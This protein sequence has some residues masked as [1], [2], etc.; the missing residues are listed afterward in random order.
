MTA[1]QG[2]SARYH[3]APE[4]AAMLLGI[5]GL[6]AMW[7]FIGHLYIS[8][9]YD[10][11]FVSAAGLGWLKHILFFHFLA[12]DMFLM[13]SGAL[14]Y[15][16]YRYYFEA[17]SKSKDIDLFY[18]HRLA[19]LYP[20]YIVTLAIIG[21]YEWV[22]IPHPVLSGMGGQIFAH[23]ELSLILNVLFMNAWGIFPVA[24]WNEPSWTLSIIMLLY[25]I[26]P[27]VVML[28]KLMPK[29]PLPLTLICVALILAYHLFREMIPNLG[30]SDGTG[31]IARG[32]VFFFIG[33]LCARLIQENDLSSWRW[34]RVLLTVTAAN[35]ALMI[36][37]FEVADFPM[38]L[39]HLLYIPLLLSLFY[40]KG[41]ITQLYGNRMFAKCGLISYGIYLLHY[42]LCLLIEYTGG[43]FL[44]SL[45]TGNAWLDSWMVLC[46]VALCCVLAHASFWLIE[47]PCNRW[48]KQRFPLK[49]ISDL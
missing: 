40:A 7:V 33:C 48:I 44:A 26:F 5:R 13:L 15:I 43:T 16:G 17:P 30:H 47:K 22:G 14:L 8:P 37:W 19:R 46:V 23:W 31:A 45:A 6:A 49:S 38:T 9:I 18:L 11:G 4:N 42:P 21:L 10:M 32:L 28:L 25:V 12:V 34:D 41:R 2:Q 20:L 24:S 27:N 39:F 29:K 3:I 1:A 36:G 35:F